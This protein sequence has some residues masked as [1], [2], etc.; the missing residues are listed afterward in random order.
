MTFEL[1]NVNNVT[2]KTSNLFCNCFHCKLWSRTCL[3]D[4]F[5]SDTSFLPGTRLVTSRTFMFVNVL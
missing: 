3:A 5:S 1:I 2:C 4:I